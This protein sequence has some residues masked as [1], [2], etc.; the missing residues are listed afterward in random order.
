MTA[1]QH[2]QHILVTDE[3][4]RE[5]SLFVQLFGEKN[6]LAHKVRFFVHIDDIMMNHLIHVSKIVRFR[7]RWENIK[8]GFF[9]STYFI[10]FSICFSI[11][12]SR[13]LNENIYGK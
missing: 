5:I 7:C 6:S 13:H 11:L 12:F 2:L 4:F 1:K 10:I 8:D 3:H 9:N